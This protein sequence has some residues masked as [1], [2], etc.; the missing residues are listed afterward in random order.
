MVS[1]FWSAGYSPTV[2][3]GGFGLVRLR[4]LAQ[5]WRARACGAARRADPKMRLTSAGVRAAAGPIRRIGDGQ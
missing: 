1:R 5:R 4:E 3:L 2:W